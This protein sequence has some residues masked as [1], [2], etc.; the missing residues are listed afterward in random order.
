VKP[1]GWGSLVPT[2]C[3]LQICLHDIKQFSSA[4]YFLYIL[5]AFEQHVNLMIFARVHNLREC[6]S[7]LSLFM[8]VLIIH[9]RSFEFDSDVDCDDDHVDADDDGGDAFILQTC[10]IILVL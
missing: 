1:R 6:L 10:I 7:P 4:N 2:F 8:L 9:V 5:D 3:L